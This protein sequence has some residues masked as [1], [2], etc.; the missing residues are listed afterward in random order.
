MVVLGLAALFIACML[1]Y[2]LGKLPHLPEE[3]EDL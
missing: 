2:A 3:G 1:A